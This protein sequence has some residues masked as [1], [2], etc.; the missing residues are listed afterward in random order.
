[1]SAPAGSCP[2]A[3]TPSRPKNLPRSK[4]AIFRVGNGKLVA[5]GA[6]LPVV[7]GFRVGNGK[8]PVGG[9]SLPVFLFAAGRPVQDDREPRQPEQGLCRE[10]GALAAGG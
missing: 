1:M 10:A 2:A 9:A 4:A 7:A 8:L 6:L 5:S 3:P